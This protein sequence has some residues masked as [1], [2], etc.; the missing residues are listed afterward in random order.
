MSLRLAWSRALVSLGLVAGLTA[1]GRAAAPA[2]PHPTADAVTHHSILLGGR[3]YAYTARAG[4]ITLRTVDDQPTARVFYTAYTLDGADLA[5]RPVTFLYNGGPGSSTIWLR[6]G[7]FGPVRVSVGDAAIT[8][9]PPYR[10]QANSYSLLDK[11]DL[12][13]IDMPGSGYGRIIGSG[14][15]KDFWGVDQD[16]DAFAQFIQRYLTNFNRWNSPKF[17]FG[18]SYGTTRSAVLSGVLATR[19]IALNGI[20]LLSSFLNPMVDYNDG[21]PI[22]GGDWAYLLYLPTE[23]ATAWYHHAIAGAPDLGGL[24][25]QSERF[26]LGEYLDGLAAGSQLPAD[27]FDDIVTKLHRFTGLS[28]RYIR[29]SNLR[30]PYDR[31]QNELARQRG[32]TFGRLDSRFQTYVLDRPEVSPDWDAT[33]SAI[34]AAFV[35]TGN[36]YVRQVLQYDTPLLYRSEIYDLIYADGN[37]WDF[38]HGDNPQ[39]FNVAPDLAQ[40]MTY[41][42]RLR[43]F[44]ANGYFDFATPFFATQYVLDHLYIAPAL[45]KNITYGFYESGH[46]VYLHPSALAKF[47]ADLERWYARTLGS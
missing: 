45:Q 9:G 27:R 3:S 42:P 30:I 34:D 44:S 37:S 32:V 43:I 5:H 2:I 23:T 17:L 11:T 15:T 10:L 14:K 41:N 29:N 25:A 1:P 39:T 7:S 46:M 36:Y 16:A 22:G 21:A 35:A 33:D 38:K 20:V 6:M 47:H 13:F 40:T 12:V 31:F 19:G 24:L 18:E 4:T 8:P 28:A 26:A